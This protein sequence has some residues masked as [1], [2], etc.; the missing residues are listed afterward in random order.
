MNYELSNKVLNY[1]LRVIPFVCFFLLLGEI[2]S[3]QD[4]F[5]IVK[6][7]SFYGITNGKGKY[8]IPSKY[9]EIQLLGTTI[10]AV[11][12]EKGLWG[13]FHIESKPPE[14]IFDNFRF[15]NSNLI[16]AQKESRWGAVNNEG[17]TIVDFRYRYL[18]PISENKFRGGLFNQWCI[19][20][21]KNNKLS[22]FEFDSLS[23][24]G[25]NVY[26]FCL[27]GKYGLVDPKGK[28]ITTEY[29]NIFE[30]TLADKYPKKEFSKTLPPIPKGTYKIPLEERFDTVYHFCEGFAKFQSDHKFGFV[31]SLGNIRLVPQYTDA[32]HFSDGMVAIVLIG[33]WGFMDKNEKLCVQP[34]YDEVSDFKNGVS[35]VRKQKQFNII[36]KEGAFLYGDFFDEIIPTYSGRYILIRNKKIGLADSSGRELVSTKYE[37]VVELGNSYIVAKEHG[38]WGVLN[39]EGNIVLPF[40]YSAIQYDPEQNRI[41]TMEPGGD[42]VVE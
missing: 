31:D 20:D 33:K 24:L 37:D 28:T 39:E 27:V 22:T 17:E 10:Y 32:R 15:I 26:K 2:V 40:N 35:V 3:A 25:D 23:Y 21:F 42:V 16:V 19:R 11:K 12:N 4:H 18:T 7:D 6:K 9:S 14:C 5:S 34:Y 30:S 1:K 41:I 36:N 13:F 38:L 8:I 29:Q